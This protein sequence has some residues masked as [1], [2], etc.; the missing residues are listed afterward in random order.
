MKTFSKNF[1]MAASW[2]TSATQ[3][4]VVEAG[5]QMGDFS[6]EGCGCGVRGYSVVPKSVTCSHA[7]RRSRSLSW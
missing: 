7:D 1:M 3:E 2:K 5:R 6:G 4:L